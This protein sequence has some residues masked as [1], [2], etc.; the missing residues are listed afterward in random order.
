MSDTI[1]T[2]LLEQVPDLLHREAWLLDRQEFRQ[3][4]SLYTADATYWVPLEKD[5]PDPIETSSIIYDDRLLLELRVEQ[6][7][8]SRAHA[9]QPLA[10]TCH[11]VGNVRI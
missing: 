7:A 5:Q 1:H 3:W 8:H 11:H 4:L 10:R 2:D 9:R 6:Y